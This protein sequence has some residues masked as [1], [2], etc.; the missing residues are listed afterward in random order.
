VKNLR[1]LGYKV[2]A[3]PFTPIKPSQLTIVKNDERKY[4]DPYFSL[5]KIYPHHD[6][7]VSNI[8]DKIMIDFLTPELFQ[9]FFA[10]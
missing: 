8:M 1:K 7:A 9:D 2:Y 10:P 3:F 6:V 4:G 5:K